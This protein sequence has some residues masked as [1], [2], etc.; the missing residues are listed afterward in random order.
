[1]IE[2][3]LDI[4]SLLR[5]K[6]AGQPEGWWSAGLLLVCGDQGRDEFIASARTPVTVRARRNPHGVESGPKTGK[7]KSSEPGNLC[8]A[9]FG[10]TEATGDRHARGQSPR[11]SRRTGKPSTW[12]R[13]AGIQ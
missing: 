2:A 4:K 1:M 6:W 13:G 10:M 11:S 7:G 12:R 8:M 5:R 3:S 9:S